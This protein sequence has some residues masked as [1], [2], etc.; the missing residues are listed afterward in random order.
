MRAIT[1]WRP[2]D[3]AIL[4]GGKRIENRPWPL[5]SCMANVPIALHAGKKFDK[6]GVRWMMERGLYIPPRDECSPTGIVGVFWVSKIVRHGEPEAA[7]KWFFGP[8]GWVISKVQPFEFPIACRGMQKLWNP[9]PDLQ[10]QI[11]EQL[12]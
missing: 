5:P 10:Q 3:Q 4:Y 8:Y 6:E 9:S 12:R 2:W 1:L 11:L 7:S